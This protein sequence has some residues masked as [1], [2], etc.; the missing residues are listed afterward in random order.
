M[1]G[2]ILRKVLF[3]FLGFGVLAASL[4]PFYAHFFVEWKPGM[5]SW[6]VPM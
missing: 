4:F 6:F 1:A 2:S 3:S 5:L